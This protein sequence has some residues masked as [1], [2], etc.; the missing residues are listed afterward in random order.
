MKLV[1]EFWGLFLMIYPKRKAQVIIIP[2][3]MVMGTSD[4]YYNKYYGRDSDSDSVQ[5]K[6]EKKRYQPDL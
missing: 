1:L 3:I 5:P 6:V 4:K 2:D